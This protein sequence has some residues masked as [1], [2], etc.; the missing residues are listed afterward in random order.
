MNDQIIDSYGVPLSP[1]TFTLE[2]ENI[3]V[4]LSGTPPNQQVVPTQDMEIEVSGQQS[5]PLTGY[6]YQIKH[7]Y[8]ES[9]SFNNNTGLDR[10]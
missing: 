5:R 9:D 2:T 6:K 4:Q 7:R 3:Y 8:E 10:K 1:T